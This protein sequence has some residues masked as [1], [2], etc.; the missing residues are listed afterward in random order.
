MPIVKPVP[1]PLV[2]FQPL[3]QE[4]LA[5]EYAGPPVI[6]LNPPYPILGP[7]VYAFPRRRRRRR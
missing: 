6:A 2:S 1:L 3:Q 5:S 7:I 4:A